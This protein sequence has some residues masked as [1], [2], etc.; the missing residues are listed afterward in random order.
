M[1]EVFE[2]YIKLKYLIE[3]N[4]SILSKHTSGKVG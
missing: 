3:L 2:K 4:K 1:Y